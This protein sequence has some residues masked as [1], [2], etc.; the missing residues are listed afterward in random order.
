MNDETDKDLKDNKS[1]VD[2]ATPE[3][4]TLEEGGIEEDTLFVFPCEFPVKCMG[5][6]GPAFEIAVVEIMNRHV[7]DLGEGAVKSRLSKEGKFSAITV[8]I[9]ATSK[10][11][12]DAIYMDLTAS[13]HVK[14]SL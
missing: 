1:N 14:M 9:T 7:P 10:K 6:T 12:L 2:D 11:Q 4:V 8:T 3:E 5:L 13:I